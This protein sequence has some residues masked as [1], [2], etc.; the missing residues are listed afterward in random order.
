VK[1]Y[2]IPMAVVLAAAALAVFMAG[3]GRAG[4][5]A[6]VPAVVV[7]AEGPRLV[8]PE[9]VVVAEAPASPMPATPLAQ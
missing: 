7:T 5:G 9:V 2:R 1:R 8:L 6:G 4:D 3:L